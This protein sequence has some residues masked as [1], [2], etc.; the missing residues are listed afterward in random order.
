LLCPGLAGD[1]VTLA[2]ASPLMRGAG[3]RRPQSASMACQ[4]IQRL[5]CDECRMNRYAI[6]GKREDER[7]DIIISCAEYGSTAQT[8]GLR[9]AVSV[10][11]GA[12]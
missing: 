12:S 10:L 1:A 9:C 8:V 6:C 4:C 7:K 3:A 2:L 5:S 11:A